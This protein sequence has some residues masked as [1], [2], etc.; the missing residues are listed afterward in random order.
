MP[1]APRLDPSLGHGE[2]RGQVV[3]PLEG[4]DHVRAL[5][6]AS[7]DD[8]AEVL[9]DVLA[10]H[11]DDPPEPGRERRADAV[12]EDELA[13]RTHGVHLLEAA[14]AAAHARRE[15]DERTDGTG[16]VLHGV[17]EVR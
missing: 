10:D 2:R 16:F 11:E 17:S 6:P 7:A 3:E 8:L 1:G 13:A 12:V 5:F 14:V 4:V 9:L 15:D